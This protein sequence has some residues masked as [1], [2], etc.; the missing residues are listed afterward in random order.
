MNR[1]NLL[2]G[3]A[4][5]LAL[6][7]ATA[8]AQPL[9]PVPGGAVPPRSDD[10]LGLMAAGLDGTYIRFADDISNVLDGVDGLRILAMIGRGSLQNLSDLL[11]L[12]RVDL[13]FVQSDVL[14][15]AAQQRLFSGL[16]QQVNYIA[17]LYDEEVHIFVRPG[18]AR[19]EDLAGRRVNVESR[20]SGTAMTAQFLFTQ[21]GLRVQ[22]VNLPS[23][24]ATELL[25][26][27][28]I[29]AVMRIA[30]KP[31][32]FSTP[33]PEGTRLLP[34]PLSEQ[35]LE[36]YLPATFTA[37]DYPGVVPEG[38]SVDTVAVGAVLACYNHQ[39]PIRRE[40]LQRFSR[41]FAQKFDAFLQPPRHPKWR[42][43]N[44]AATLPGWT[45][46]DP[47]LQAASATAAPRSRQAA[48]SRLP[49][50]PPAD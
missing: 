7:A 19:L 46:F 1:R 16:Q 18:I 37:R 17:K 4:G 14:A 42:D 9:P 15:A 22:T 36:A 13:T 20:Q 10:T 12:P 34:V 6:R 33:M 26:R 23:N 31:I 29:D 28:E 39:N 24:D 41:A 3:L 30:G 49:A 25:R 47:T 8:G 40:R 50:N 35:L 44:L 38:E 27:G 48:R 45:R 5:G 2:A 43:V 32:R 11:Y 21:L